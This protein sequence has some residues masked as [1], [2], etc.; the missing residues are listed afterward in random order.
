MPVEKDSGRAKSGFFR[1]DKKMGIRAPLKEKDSGRAKSGFVRWDNK[2]G[3]R[4][5]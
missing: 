4:A 2:M 5:H 3:L 1:W